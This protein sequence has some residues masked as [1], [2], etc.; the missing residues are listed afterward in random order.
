MITMAF[1]LSFLLSVL[2]VVERNLKKNMC[3]LNNNPVISFSKEVCAHNEALG[4]DLLTG[5]CFGS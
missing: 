4:L 1:Q 5:P 2:D 3:D